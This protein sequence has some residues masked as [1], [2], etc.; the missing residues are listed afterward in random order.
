MNDAGI[1]RVQSF[2]LDGAHEIANPDKVYV[3]E[4]EPL[5][6]TTVRAGERTLKLVAQRLGIK[7][8]SLLALN[9][10][11]TY[12]ITIQPN[13]YVQFA[14]Q[15]ANGKSMGLR[16]VTGTLRGSAPSDPGPCSMTRP[17]NFGS[18]TAGFVSGWVVV[19]QPTNPVEISAQASPKRQYERMGAFMG[20]WAKR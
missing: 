20:L 18:A 11:P 19:L 3:P 9:S 2:N 4:T 17:V 16:Q 10:G 5:R 14:D 13:R 15:W 7:L 6:S 1:V 8:P 12:T